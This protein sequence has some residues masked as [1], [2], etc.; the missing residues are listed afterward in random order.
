MKIQSSHNVAHVTTAQLLWH[1][2]ICDIEESQNR[3]KETKILIA[4]SRKP[5]VKCV[6]DHNAV[7]H[8]GISG[9][10]SAPVTAWNHAGLL[11]SATRS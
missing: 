1:V 10:R 2:Q 7:G 11:S 4:N 8:C 6:P 3:R 9:V 5:Y